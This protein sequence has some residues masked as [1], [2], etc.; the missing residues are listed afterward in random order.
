MLSA[1]N[2][3]DL[4]DAG[5]R[6]IVGSRIAKAANDLASYFHWQ[7]DVFNDGQIIDTITPRDQRGTAA[8]S[9]DRKVKAEPVWN[10]NTNTKS[11]RAVWACS[12]KR[13]MRDNKTLNLGGFVWVSDSDT[14][15]VSL[16]HCRR[17][18]TQVSVGGGGRVV[19]VSVQSLSR[20]TR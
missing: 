13:A 7:G 1:G 6:F 16:G 19:L 15:P 18:P 11:W 20:V 8:K 5:F 2:L 3:R 9:S 12:T 4:D 14:G 17:L 10:P